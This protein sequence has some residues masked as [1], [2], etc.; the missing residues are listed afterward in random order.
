MGYLKIVVVHLDEEVQ[1]RRVVTAVHPGRMIGGVCWQG[2]ARRSAA[3]VER[4]PVEADQGDIAR[5]HVAASDHAR[6]LGQVPIARPTVNHDRAR[7]FDV[8][9]CDRSV[10]S[11]GEAPDRSRC[12]AG[13][14]D[15]IDAPVVGRIDHERS[16]IE[17][18]DALVTLE[19]RWIT[20]S[21][22]DI[23]GHRVA[24]CR[25]AH[26]DAEGKAA[27]PVGGARL[28]RRAWEWG[29]GQSR[30][31]GHAP[32]IRNLAREAAGLFEVTPGV[33][34]AQARV[35]V[36]VV[37][38]EIEVDAEASFVRKAGSQNTLVDLDLEPP[39]GRIHRH[40]RL[41]ATQDLRSVSRR[42][43]ID[44]SLIRRVDDQLDVR[45]GVVEASRATV[46]TGADIDLHTVVGPVHCDTVRCSNVVVV[47]SDEE[48]HVGGV[49]TAVHLRGVIGTVTG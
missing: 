31:P 34:S 12:G 3:I 10:P 13:A 44:V 38:A 5:D 47:H 6:E 33:D 1:I 28:A 35:V 43:Y 29:Q 48:V 30:K 19:Q 22:I 18:S 25:P 49:V 4:P 8:E 39:T 45:R 2:P 46:A 11:G 7:L 15:F 41:N 42:G 27:R 37:V 17:P 24:T 20:R 23:V 32:S 16:R 9:C 40:R 21:E 36:V 14:V 26:V